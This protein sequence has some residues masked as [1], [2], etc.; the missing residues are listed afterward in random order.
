MI[1]N[2]KIVAV[3]ILGIA[4]IFSLAYGVIT[5]RAGRP[6]ISAVPATGFVSP[7]EA[8][9]IQ[10]HSRRARRTQCTSW[11]RNLFSL[12]GASGDGSSDSGVQGIMWSENDPMAIV[13]G[14]IV[15]KGDSVAGGTVAD[16]RKDAVIIN[17]G[18]KDIEVAVNSPP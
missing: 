16:I 7:D 11:K 14:C 10:M 12:T 8:I 4:A 17:D 3:V 6:V 9:H 18:S 15:H 1:K 5:S 2:K 13:D